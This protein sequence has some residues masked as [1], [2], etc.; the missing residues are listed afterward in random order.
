MTVTM[1]QKLARALLGPAPGETDTS[2][3]HAESSPLASVMVLTA[4][5]SIVAGMIHI[6][7]S[8]DHAQEFLLYAPVFALLAALQIAWGASVVRGCSRRVLLAGSVLNLAVIGLWVASRTI[9]V[10]IAARPWVPEPVGAPDLMATVAEA[11]IVLATTCLLTSLRSSLAQRILARLAPVL[12]AVIFLCV[13]FGV[14][15]HAH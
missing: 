2:N 8:I 5:V 1:T 9:G 10:P 14:G 4:G 6:R 15:A 7:A 12:L 11:V 3:S 13:T